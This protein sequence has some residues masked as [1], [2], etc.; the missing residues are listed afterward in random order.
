M[1]VERRVGRAIANPT[2]PYQKPQVH[3][4]AGNNN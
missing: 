1:A 2:I 4:K 3:D